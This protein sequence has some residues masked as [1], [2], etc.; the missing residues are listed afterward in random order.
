MTLVDEGLE[1]LDPAECWHLLGSRAVGR[2]GLSV[3]TAPAIFPVNYRLVGQTIVFATGTGL[4]LNAAR[5]ERLLA[6]EVD[7]VDEDA[8]RGWSVLVVGV[9]S[10]LD[11]PTRQLCAAMDPWAGGD[12][13][14]LVRIAVEMISGRRIVPLG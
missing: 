7:D 1:I 10:E 5:S 11:E 12:R 6:F 9:A 13:S 14:H 4:K 8:H 2:V 3:N